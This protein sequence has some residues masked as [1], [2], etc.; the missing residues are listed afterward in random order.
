[1]LE[2][3]KPINVKWIDKTKLRPKCEVER[4]KARLLAKG[5]VPKT[6]LDYQETYTHVARIE[7]IRLLMALATFKGWKMQ[8][9]DVKSIF[10]NGSL[11][12]E[13]HVS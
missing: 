9:L 12:E 11:K 3:K 10:L 13:V 8:Q 4:F 7:T 6:G 1:M 2:R 5:F